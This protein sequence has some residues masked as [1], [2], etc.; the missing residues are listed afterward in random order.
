MEDK[1]P[2]AE[3]LIQ[4]R[5]IWLAKYMVKDSL[6]RAISQD[7]SSKPARPAMFV[8]SP[9]GVTLNVLPTVDGK[10]G[11]TVK[12]SFESLRDITSNRYAPR[13]LLVVCLDNKN[14]F[15]IMVCSAEHESDC[16]ELAAAYTD[17]RKL[18]M[19]NRSHRERQLQQQ[20]H[21]GVH[22]WTL[23]P[24]AG[25]SRRQVEN[26][27]G[28]YSRISSSNYNHNHNSNRRGTNSSEIYETLDGM[29]E[30]LL[31][32]SSVEGEVFV[33]PEVIIHHA[34][35]D[36][37]REV[38]MAGSDSYNV[39]VQTEGELY[40]DTD[41][42]ISSTS[43]RSLRED[44]Q[45]LS[46]EMRAIKF[47]L[48]TSTGIS[49]EEYFRK[50]ELEGRSTPAAIRGEVKELEGGVKVK[51]LGNDK[52]DAAGV[53]SDSGSF[54]VHF[55]N[56]TSEIE[57][58][59]ADYDLRSVG[60]QTE[61]GGRSS[62]L[63]GGQRYAKRTSALSS[64]SSNA[65]RDR[66]AAADRKRGGAGSY[67]NGGQPRLSSSSSSGAGVYAGGSVGRNG[68]AVRK[69]SSHHSQVVNR[70]GLVSKPIERQNYSNTGSRGFG[71]RRNV[72]VVVVPTAPGGNS[73]HFRPQ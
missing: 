65:Y 70:S 8:L 44:L 4:F 2:L 46:E 63:I 67:H 41:S 39:G 20:Q 66:Q 47:L 12:V 68:G 26:E 28:H 16:R 27:E 18:L 21:L 57:E 49:A 3:K 71:N 50:H 73:G 15:S 54:Q 42:I 43:I 24:G 72:R 19:L 45:S 32:D 1:K 9:S 23:R 13:C 53:S 51:S 6:I 31:S 7:Y 64:S 33:V 69:S 62:T 36:L 37:E 61:T 58:G 14:M 60:A 25:G 56:G 30:R 10:P 38:A 40:S 5:G 35:E 29:G 22:N 48:E 17:Y 55:Q 34:E 11:R 59:D 52:N